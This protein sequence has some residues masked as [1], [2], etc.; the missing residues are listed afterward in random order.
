[1]LIVGKREPKHSFKLD[2]RLQNFITAVM[3]DDASRV[4]VSLIVGQNTVT[5]HCLKAVT[6]LSR[7]SFAEIQVQ[8][9]S[10]SG[11]RATDHVLH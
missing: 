3:G 9:A 10:Y 11:N 8:T 7:E 2:C 1:M 4:T 6:Q 5:R